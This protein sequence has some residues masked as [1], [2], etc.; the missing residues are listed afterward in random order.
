MG[1]PLVDH[2]WRALLNPNA[3]LAVRKDGLMQTT[4]TCMR[5]RLQSK[6]E[7]SRQQLTWKPAT[8]PGCICGPDTP[9]VMATVPSLTRRRQ[10]CSIVFVGAVM[11][12]IT[13]DIRRGSQPIFP[14]RRGVRPHNSRNAGRGGASTHH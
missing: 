3:E 14:L 5:A 7:K 4:F 10:T 9:D 12:N 11:F 6:N 13:G 2:P 1:R 8:S